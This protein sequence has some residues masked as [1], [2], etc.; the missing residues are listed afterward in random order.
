MARATIHTFAA[1]GGWINQRSRSGAVRQV[2]K[3]AA[4]ARRAGEDLAKRDRTE[5]V[6]HG[7]DGRVAA[8][9]SFD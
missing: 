9:S 5:H 1:N 2:Y 3:T 4:E 8:R 6:V 7:I